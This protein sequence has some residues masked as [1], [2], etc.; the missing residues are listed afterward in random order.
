M[1]IYPS[2]HKAKQ[3]EHPKYLD[4]PVSHIE[5]EYNPKKIVVEKYGM[6]KVISV[7][8][9][10]YKEISELS[11][12]KECHP[13]VEI[14]AS[15]VAWLQNFS[16]SILRTSKDT[17]FPL[18]NS[19]LDITNPEISGFRIYLSDSEFTHVQVRRVPKSRSMYQLDYY[20]STEDGT[21]KILMVII[22]D[23]S[24]NS[25]ASIDMVYASPKLELIDNGMSKEESDLEYARRIATFYRYIQ[26]YMRNW[27][28]SSNRC[29]ITPL[30]FFGKDILEVSQKD[31]KVS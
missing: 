9:T 3:L 11:S 8:P 24:G 21:P 25:F 6:K 17:R 4:I 28:Y 12:Q 1:K 18:L 29:S 27:D 23:V 20:E 19:E 5:N 31:K 13:F 7:L 26:V 2:P 30:L 10:E 22:V 14:N 15:D 16:E